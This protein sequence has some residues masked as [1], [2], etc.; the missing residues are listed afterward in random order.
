MKETEED[1]LYV[2]RGY[3]R[4]LTKFWQEQLKLKLGKVENY[5]LQ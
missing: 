2:E 4:A 5:E 3:T 1:I